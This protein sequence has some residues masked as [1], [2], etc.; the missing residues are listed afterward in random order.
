MSLSYLCARSCPHDH[1]LGRVVLEFRSRFIGLVLLVTLAGAFLR[2]DA[3]SYRVTFDSGSH[4][5]QNSIVSFDCP[6][7][8]WNPVL[9]GNDPVPPV[10]KGLDGR[11]HTRLSGW[12]AHERR[13]FKLSN[14]ARSARVQ[15]G[16]QVER[17]GGALQFRQDET[18]IV[19][20]QGRP[21]S[22][23]SPGID[24][25]FLR[26]GYLHPL[27]SPTGLVV[28]DD[29][30]VNHLHHHGVWVSWTK[31][32]FDG[33]EPNFWEM[34]YKK[35][36]VEFVAMDNYWS[37]PV[38]GGVRSRHR[39]VDLTL[40]SPVVVLNERWELK[41]YAVDKAE[42]PY[43]MF[44]LR[45]VQECATDKPLELPRYRYGG[46]GF[47]GRHEW[48]GPKNASFLTGLGETDR[49]KGH[50]TRAP[51]CHIGGLV[52][53]TFTGAAIFCDPENFRA[54]QPM[55]IHPKEPFFCYAPSQAG[56]WI[57]EPGKPY[58]SNY[59]FV[60]FDGVPEKAFLDQ[61]W[62]DFANP[63]VVTLSQP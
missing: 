2:I 1:W 59:R 16:I 23:P 14:D 7:G 54:P 8:I 11:L 30:P 38:F 60:I 24:L 40:A 58:V 51:W 45:F 25:S 52:D 43:H 20:Y 56:D 62:Q 26:G 63:V 41:A 13:T 12:S 15:T 46:L 44:D 35:G 39:Y 22:L 53:G 48:D 55:R 50:A 21:G 4:S 10:Q 19:Q 3:E 33:R 6:E 31:T 9:V 61:L 32:K 18:P 47:R 42:R 5:R 49:V 34:G 36:T 57:I 27:W 29:Y 28:T 17:L 37:G